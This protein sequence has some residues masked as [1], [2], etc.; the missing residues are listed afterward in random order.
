ML[1]EWSGCRLTSLKS[2]ALQQCVFCTPLRRI[3]GSYISASCLARRE[4]LLEEDWWRQRTRDTA[5][6]FPSFR[7]LPSCFLIF[8][9]A[10]CDIAHLRC[11]SDLRSVRQF[12]EQGPTNL[13]G[14]QA[15]MKQTTDSLVCFMTACGPLQAPALQ[16]SLA[17]CATTRGSWH[18]TTHR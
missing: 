14:P 5:S 10:Q 3:S 17:E 4:F 13:G 15:V 18:S 1:R 12:A 7:H 9:S 2:P 16:S 6:P 11:R 8:V